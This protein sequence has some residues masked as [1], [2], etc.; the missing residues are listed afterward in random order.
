M[1]DDL[2]FVTR[3]DE[4]RSIC[5]SPLARETVEEAGA[6]HLG[7]DKG[8]FIYEVNDNPLANGINILAKVVSLEAAFRLVELWRDQA[9]EMVITT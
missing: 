1:D 8:Y 4:H 5:L 6:N 2:L 7:G 3:L 9:R